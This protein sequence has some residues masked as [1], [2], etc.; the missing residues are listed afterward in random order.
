[1]LIINNLNYQIYSPPCF[2]VTK[3]YRQ[4]TF[5]KLLS[6]TLSH[7]QKKQIHLLFQTVSNFLQFELCLIVNNSDLGFI[8]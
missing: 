5:V 4:K 1:M 3:I 6:N 8:P 2:T 7:H